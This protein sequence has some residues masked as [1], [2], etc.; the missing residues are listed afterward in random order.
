LKRLQRLKGRP[1]F[2]THEGSTTAT[3]TYL[4]ATGIKGDFTFLPIPFRN[5]SDACVLRDLPERRQLRAWLARVV[6]GE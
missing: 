3:E 4:K 5:H 1:Q 6:A 2:I